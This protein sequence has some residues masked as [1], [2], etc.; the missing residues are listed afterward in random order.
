MIETLKALNRIKRMGL[1]KDYAIAGGYAVNYYLEPRFTYD[2]DLFIVLSYEE[3]FH[4]LYKFFRDAG[5]KIE[6]VYIWI[7]GTPVQFFPTYISPLFAE[8]V[9]KARRIRVRGVTAKVLS[10][11]YL[12][13]TLLL[14][15]R[16][17]DRA[18]IPDLLGLSNQNLI[19]DIVK[20][21]SDEKTP[22]D[23]RLGRVLADLH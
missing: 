23:Q 5:N 1:V 15:F 18:V 20:R 3:D 14:A 10:V 12:V 19:R 2:L 4:Q 16:S 21:F 22:L 7:E 9:E 8:A 17:K 6:N 13:A 11:E